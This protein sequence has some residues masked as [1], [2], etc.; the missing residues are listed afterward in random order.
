V[1]TLE[2]TYDAIACDRDASR[3]QP[4]EWLKFFLPFIKK[5]WVVLDAGC[6]NANNAI[7]IARRAKRVVCL[8]FSQK[9][10]ECARE[11]ARAANAKN[12]KFVKADVVK[13][14]LR[15]AAFDAAVYVAVLCHLRPGREQ[16]AAFKEMNRVLKPHGTAFASIWNKTQHLFAEIRGKSALVPGAAWGG[17]RFKRYYYFFDEKEIRALAR[18]HGFRVRELFYERKG[19]KTAREGAWNVCFILEKIKSA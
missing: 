4:R 15:D 7:E 17:K 3:K 9:T 11:N 16:G 6:G 2:K 10:L 12:I 8:D 5:K 14:P 13:L 18:A 19:V 1:K